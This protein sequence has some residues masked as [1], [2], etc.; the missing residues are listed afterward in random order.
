MQST[1]YEMVNVEVLANAV[2]KYLDEEIADAGV[3]P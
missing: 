1:F 3:E 2:L